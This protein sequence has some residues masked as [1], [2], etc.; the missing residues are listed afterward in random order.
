MDTNALYAQR[1]GDTTLVLAQR[2]CQLVGW[3]PTLEEEIALANIG[4][5]YLG[6]T[7]AWLDLAARREGKGRS[8]DDLAY[9]RDE[10]DFT[11]YLLAELDNGDFAQ[12]ILRGYFFS[13]YFLAL[14]QA[15][16]ASGDEDFCAI[17]GKSLKE[18]EYHALHEREWLLRFAHGTGESRA[19]LEKAWDY[20]WPYTEELFEALGDGLP[21][22]AD[23]RKTWRATIDAL[24]QECGLTIPE[25]TYFQSGGTQ[26]RHTEKLGLLLAEMQSLR[27]AHPGA[28][29]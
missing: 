22:M 5:D 6:Q 25:N 11:N 14:Y 12:T 15:L 10:R 13:S 4:L 3:A 21:D 29:W 17:A 1:L 19:R 9:F 23:I 2:Y 28:S 8:A 20:L 16:A 27:R 24:A 26:G 18:V 7:T